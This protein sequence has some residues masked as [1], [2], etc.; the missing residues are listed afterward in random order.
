M[1]ITVCE[2]PDVREGFESVWSELCGHVRSNRSEMVLLP[3]MTAH[4]WF[5]HKPDF[6]EKVWREALRNHDELLER[7]AELAPAAVLSSRPVEEEVK[8]FNRGFLW[9]SAE[10]YAPVHDKRYLPNQEGYY[11]A[12]WFHRGEFGFTP[13]AVGNVSVGFLICTDVMFGER[14]R[15]LGKEGSHVIAAPRA[16]AA[17]DRWEIALRM[18]AVVSGAFVI[19]S[20]RTGE[21]ADGE[22]FVF[23]GAGFVVSPEGGVLARTSG[24]EP[25]VTVEIDPLEAEAAK[26]GYPRN[27]PE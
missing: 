2:L 9:T 14:A 25:F 5:A 3:E 15:G 12:R 11:E 18:A 20:N 23:G 7:L 19:S 27:I 10:G 8:R 26:E 24:E 1:K 6:E 4:P 22:G 21:R 17:H 16:T 13:V